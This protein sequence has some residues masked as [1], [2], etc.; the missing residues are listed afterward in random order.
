MIVYHGKQ[1]MDTIQFN[2]T[3]HEAALLRD[4]ILQN[5][6]VVCRDVN[7]VITKFLKS[8]GMLNK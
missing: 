8:H 2:L 5:K 6:N 4:G 3:V 7:E 1:L